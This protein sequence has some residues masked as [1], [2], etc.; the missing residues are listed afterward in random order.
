M[1]SVLLRSA[2]HIYSFHCIHCIGALAYGIT[3]PTL[4]KNLFHYAYFAL[5]NLPFKRAMKTS[6]EEINDQ[7]YK[8]ETEQNNQSCTQL[9]QLGD[10]CDCAFDGAMITLV[11]ITDAAHLVHGPNGCIGNYWGGR[12]SLSSGSLMY[13]NCFTS[14]M[15]ESDIIF[16]GAKKLYRAILELQR[17]YKPAAI[18]VYST[19]VSALI[20]DDINGAC[21]EAAE[22]TGTP[23]IPV[24]APGFVGH[25]NQGI[26]LANEALLEYVIGTA[27]PNTTTLYDIN[28]I[29]EYNIGGDIWN[30]L[31]MLEELGI[32]VLAKITGDAR[33]QEICYAHR[34]KLNVVNSSAKA[35]LKM[36]RQMEERFHIPYITE[37]FYGV[38]NLNRCLRN[39]AAK[40]GDTELQ[41]RT[42]N[43]INSET[44]SLNNQL[45][46]Y[47]P[48]LQG[49][50]ILIDI[51]NLNNWAIV[52]AIQY[53]EM[54]VILTSTN[55]ITQDNQRKIKGL[56]G[57]NTK[58]LEIEISQLITEFK[59]DLLIATNHYQATAMKTKIPFLDINQE[60]K[61]A[62]TGYAGII[63]V[64]QELYTT[65][66]SPVWEQV[67]RPA[68]WE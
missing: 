45:D 9:S 19:C 55:K 54:E 40:L 43:L 3:H 57:E 11:P 58:I 12:D 33:Y 1:Y 44:T 13:K 26:R 20:G 27:E 14:D 67:R 34:A 4:N 46:F 29:G 31:P 66:H 7:L 30:I 28:L 5:E 53:L 32:R 48:S 65:L 22:I 47:L 56:F 36:A 41:V 16:G 61:N 60:R 49:K 35:M 37:S 63:S 39:I 52:S 59:P 50:R 25:R 10:N 21:R 8:S 42:E 23:V 17:R 6:K 18:F 38:E 15:D 51:T 2:M 68:P 24:D 64:A 62:Y